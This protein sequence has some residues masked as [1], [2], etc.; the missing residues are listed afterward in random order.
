MPHR[1]LS[2][3]GKNTVLIPPENTTN[4][5]DLSEKGS[6]LTFVFNSQFACKSD[7]LKGK[8]KKV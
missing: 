7:L 5:V 4:R 3:S 6:Y 1:Q 8:A 2:T